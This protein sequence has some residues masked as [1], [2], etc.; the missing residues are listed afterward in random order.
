MEIWQVDLRHGG[1]YEFTVIWILYLCLSPLPAAAFF[2]LGEIFSR[3]KI[4]A[5]KVYIILKALN[6]REMEGVFFHDRSTRKT[7][8]SLPWVP[9]GLW[10]IMVNRIERIL[11]LV[12]TR[13][14]SQPSSQSAGWGQHSGTTGTEQNYWRIKERWFTRRRES[15]QTNISVRIH[16]NPGYVFR[17]INFHAQQLKAKENQNS[18]YPPPSTLLFPWTLLFST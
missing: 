16:L 8:I 9:C 7:P 11:W 17:I 12:R 6:L 15:V 13:S 2:I 14:C 4:L 18:K 10:A 5:A 1:I 3:R